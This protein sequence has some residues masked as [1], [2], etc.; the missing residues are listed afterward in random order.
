MRTT[1]KFVK[2]EIRNRCFGI[3]DDAVKQA[4]EMREHPHDEGFVKQIDVIDHRQF[5]LALIDACIER[6]VEFRKVLFRLRP[7]VYKRDALVRTRK[8]NL[9]RKIEEIKIDLKDRCAA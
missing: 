9:L 5:E 3:C 1:Y 7:G 2:P 6:Q 8:T 4:F